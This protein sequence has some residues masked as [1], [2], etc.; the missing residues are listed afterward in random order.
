VQRDILD[1]PA[2]PDRIGRLA[3]A[4]ELTGDDVARAYAAASATPAREGW[5]LLVD[6]TLLVLG[7]LLAVAGVIF[8]FTFN[9]DKLGSSGKFGLIGAG[10]VLSVAA[11][12]QRTLARVGGRMALVAAALLVGPLLAVY[13]QTY[14]TGAD[15]FE[16]FLLWALLATPWAIAARSRLLWG[17]I[18]A[19]ADVAAGLFAEQVL[20]QADDSPWR[21]GAEL[22]IVAGIHL[23]SLVALELAAKG[24]RKLPRLV[25]LVGAGVVSFGAAWWVFDK[26]H[27]QMA[28]A[29]CVVCTPFAWVG[30]IHVYRRRRRD[31]AMLA[32]AGASMVTVTTSVVAKILSDASDSGLATAF[33]TGLTLTGEVAALA[34]WLRHETKRGEEA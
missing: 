1:G 12:Q 22:P 4:G 32:V 27:S 13:G 26:G 9:W 18:I 20:G 30:L 25:A 10:I 11:A 2:T 33:F 15:P 19:L 29:L 24:D 17:V 28:P 14:Q 8:F 5:A 23:V 6:R 31:M 21:D 34:F 7:A 16:L 3:A